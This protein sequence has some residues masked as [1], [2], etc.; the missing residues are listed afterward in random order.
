LPT[1]NRRSAL[2]KLGL[3]LAASTSLAAATTVA[4]TNQPNT[5]PAP[6]DPIFALI[7]EHKS[8]LAAIN[9][10]EGEM[11]EEALR[12]LDARLSDIWSRL[13]GTKPKTIAGVAALL[14]YAPESCGQDDIRQYCGSISIVRAVETAAA[15][16]RDMAG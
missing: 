15:A 7:E 6:L 16:L 4:A 1:I 10:Y 12:A 13:F 5:A 14:S 3:G 9:T 2:A 11:E 8:A